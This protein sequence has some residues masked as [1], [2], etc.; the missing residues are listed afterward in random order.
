MTFR[1]GSY[2]VYYDS[3][4]RAIDSF[5]SINGTSIHENHERNADGDVT[6]Y[7]ETAESLFTNAV[8][9]GGQRNDMGF[10]CGGDKNAMDKIV[11]GYRSPYGY[12]GACLKYPFNEN[13]TDK[14]IN[15][16]YQYQGHNQNMSIAG[17]QYADVYSITT[18]TMAN[19]RKLKSHFSP[20][21]GLIRFS[22]ID[23][24]ITKHDWCLVRSRIIR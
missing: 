24:G 14:V 22:L 16:T 2:F 15:Y 10:Y 19:E 3:V 9:G 6:V 23:S 21:H 7:W 5:Y 20:E 12:S 1:Q 8:D 11:V 17:K 4:T 18:E 13:E